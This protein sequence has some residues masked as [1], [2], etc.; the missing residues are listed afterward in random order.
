MKNRLYVFDE[1]FPLRTKIIRKS[2]SAP[3]VDFFIY[4]SAF[5]SEFLLL[6]CSL[7][8]KQKNILWF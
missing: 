2:N 5:P 6:K 4:T 7:V 3:C 1:K 8:L